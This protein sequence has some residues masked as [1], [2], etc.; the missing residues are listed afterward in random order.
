[1]KKNWNNVLLDY[2]MFGKT[3][4]C[5]SKKTFAKMR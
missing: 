4:L 5:G 3:K 2:W 1:M